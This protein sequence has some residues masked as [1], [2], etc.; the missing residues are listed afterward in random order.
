MPIANP[1]GDTVS[2]EFFQGWTSDDSDPANVNA[3]GGVL[4]VGQLTV[5]A[6]GVVNTPGT[7]S[8]PQ[9]S[10][11]LPTVTFVS[12]T[13]R[14]LSGT[15][16]ESDASLWVPW[17]TDG[18]NN[19]ASLLLELSPDN[20]TYSPLG[21]PSIAAAVNLAGAH[22]FLQFLLVPY[23]WYVRLTATHATIGTA[24]GWGVPRG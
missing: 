22:T 4:D 3:N 15:T 9:S 13:G 10:G 5:D 2:G 14:N 21:T 20:T 18:T 23:T 24:T 12:G 6:G 1:A 17:T 16:F 8:V 7:Q 11:A 19:V